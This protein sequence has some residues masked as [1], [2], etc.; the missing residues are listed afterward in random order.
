MATCRMPRLVGLQRNVSAR[1]R[2]LNRRAP[3]PFPALQQATATTSLLKIVLNAVA[4]WLHLFCGEE[5]KVSSYIGE[6]QYN[7]DGC[8]R[9]VGALA[10]EDRVKVTGKAKAKG[11]REKTEQGERQRDRERSRRGERERKREQRTDNASGVG[12]FIYPSYGTHT[13]MLPAQPAMIKYLQHEENKGS[14]HVKDD[15]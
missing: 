7:N 12:P 9:N 2:T 10:R 15:F 3:T 5:G 13:V 8:S 6:K 11:W 14:T 1:N 4:V